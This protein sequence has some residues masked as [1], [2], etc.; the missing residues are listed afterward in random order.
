MRLTERHGR[1]LEAIGAETRAGLPNLTAT[2]MLNVD[3][4]T[5]EVAHHT[6]DVTRAAVDEML[7]WL[8]TA[9]EDGSAGASSS[10]TAATCSRPAS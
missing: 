8:T 3:G 6:G 4:T 7:A 2:R 9:P 1:D 5:A 10:P